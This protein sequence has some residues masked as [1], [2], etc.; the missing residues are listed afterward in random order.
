VKKNEPD[1]SYSDFI[2]SLNLY[3]R[4][5]EGGAIRDTRPKRFTELLRIV[6][7]RGTSM[8]LLFS[9]EDLAA[10]VS[11]HI[12]PNKDK[13]ALEAVPDVQGGEEIITSFGS[14]GD[15]GLLYGQVLSLLAQV[16]ADKRMTRK[17]PLTA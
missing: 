9:A 13:T 3:V 11:G 15:K 17:L 2:S 5:E 4:I 16:A 6:S 8:L 7:E 14:L 12:R 1:V 10:M